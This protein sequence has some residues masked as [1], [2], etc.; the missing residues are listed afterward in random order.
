MV[1]ADARLPSISSEG[2]RPVLSLREA[3]LLADVPETK[4]RKDIETRLL[5]P[6]RVGDPDRLFFRWVD[7]FFFAALYKNNLLSSTLRKKTLDRLEAMVEPA[8]RREFYRL[9]G[10]DSLLEA[11]RTL[12]RPSRMLMNCD[13][14]K[15]DEH[16][17]IDVRSLVDELA[18]C[19]DLYADGL[20]RIEERK[21]ILG[22]E[23]VFRGTRLS[24]RHV[25]KMY[26]AGESLS[27]IVEDY[28]YLRENDIK[29]AQLFHMAHPAI[30][31]PTA[32]GELDYAGDTS[33]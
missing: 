12:V 24:V 31:R 3:T 15:L 7:V 32:K 29:F 22:G 21:G 23:A 6:I 17:F 13:R 9:R 33:S 26:D 2:V 20:S 16:I 1:G 14:V 19:I 30:G 4:V 8:F 5:I 10:L 27:N 25:G 18:P 11:N 28:P